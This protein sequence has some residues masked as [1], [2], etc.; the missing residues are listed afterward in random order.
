M[1]KCGAK[2]RYIAALKFTLIVDQNTALTNYKKDRL[3]IR[4]CVVNSKR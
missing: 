1:Y 2:Y 4:I 3:R